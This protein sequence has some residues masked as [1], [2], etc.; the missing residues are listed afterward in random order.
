MFIL[1]MYAHMYYICM[2]GLNVS[3][4]V[5]KRTTNH[6]IENNAFNLWINYIKKSIYIFTYKKSYSYIF[7]QNNHAFTRP[8]ICLF[9]SAGKQQWGLWKRQQVQEVQ[10]AKKEL[11]NS[12]EV[13]TLGVTEP[14]INSQLE[15]SAL[16]K[17]FQVLAR[18]GIKNWNIYIIWIHYALFNEIVMDYKKIWH[19][20]N[21][22]Y[23][24]EPHLVLLLILASYPRY[25]C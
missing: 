4:N 17:Y 21:I 23:R 7:G 14:S 5:S 2:P 11:K 18:R 25:L 16:R 9:I 12:K 15:G 10:I 24:S 19:V 13:L 6:V 1:Y 20:I 3:K 22:D 8:T